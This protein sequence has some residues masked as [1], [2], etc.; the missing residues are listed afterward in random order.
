LGLI[1]KL[2]VWLLL[3][4]EIFDEEDRVD[5]LIKQVSDD[6]WLVKGK[7]FIRTINKKLNLSLPITNEF[8]PVSRF[9]MERIDSAEKDK[10]FK[11]KDNEVVITIKQVHNDKILLVSIKKL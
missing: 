6:E 3:V 9:L 11:C 8:K 4:G 1:S 5:S 10:F 2:L 7:T